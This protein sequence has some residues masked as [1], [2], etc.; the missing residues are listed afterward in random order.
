VRLAATVRAGRAMTGARPEPM[1][2]WTAA[3]ADDLPDPLPSPCT[4]QAVLEA[5]QDG[6]LERL[7]ARLSP[8][9]RDRVD[10]WMEDAQTLARDDAPWVLDLVAA[11]AEV[12]SH[13][14]SLPAHAVLAP[15]DPSMDA[16]A[17][18]LGPAIG[19][20]GGQTDANRALADTFRFLGGRFDAG[21]TGGIVVG[22][23]P[24]PVDRLARWG[25]LCREAHG[26]AEKA[27]ALWV[28]ISDPVQ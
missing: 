17:V 22:S 21:A 4:P 14:L 20:S 16:V 2:R 11:L 7:M 13:A 9:V 3:S 6:R 10:D 12:A 1:S 27:D 26:A 24:A 8:A 23:E 15:L 19:A 25:W 28:R 18:A 5:R